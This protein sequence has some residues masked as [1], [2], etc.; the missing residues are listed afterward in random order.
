MTKA[1]IADFDAPIDHRFFEDYQAGAKYSYGWITV[2]EAEVLE[3]AR[4]FDTQSIHIDPVAAAAG[5]FGG[6]IASGWHTTAIMMRLLAD[7]YVSSNASL[8]SPGVDELRWTAPVR[9]GDQLALTATVA[10]ARRSKSKPDRGLVHTAV[11]LFNQHDQV[12]LTLTA[13]NFIRTKVS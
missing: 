13:M 1:L 11:E 6:L 7:H 3:F 4:R 10:S 2:T 9:P 5:P 8:A 12:V